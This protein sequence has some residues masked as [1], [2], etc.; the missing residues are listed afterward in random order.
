MKQ[1]FLIG[2][3]AA[4]CIILGASRS[5]AQALPEPEAVSRG[6]EMVKP[7]AIDPKGLPGPT[8]KA[9]PASVKPVT[10]PV[11]G[12]VVLPPTP[13]PPPPIN[14]DDPKGNTKQ[15]YKRLGPVFSNPKVRIDLKIGTIFHIEQDA[16]PTTGYQWKVAKP[17]DSRVINLLDSRYLG[18]DSQLIG[19]GGKE[20]WTFKVV[21]RGKTAVVLEYSRPWEKEGDKQTVV[22][23]V[24]VSGK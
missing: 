20:V 17:F 11:P 8:P 13:P 18:P 16:N 4:G 19:A 5:V 23:N 22:F 3:C 9:E 14:Q 7:D 12:P 10:P 6:P 21:G 15:S 2:V 24:V 1:T